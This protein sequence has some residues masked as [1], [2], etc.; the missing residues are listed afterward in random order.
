M[1]QQVAHRDRLAVGRD[2]P[3]GGELGHVLGQGRIEDQLAGVAQRQDRERRHVL[4]HRGDPERGVLAHPP[5]GL[6]VRQPQGHHMDEPSL[7]DDTGDK[8]R[9]LVLPGKSRRGSIDF[10]KHHG[11]LAG[12]GSSRR[13]LFVAGNPAPVPSPFVSQAGHEQR[14]PVVQRWH[15]R[16]P[17]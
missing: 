3:H 4:G 15:S 10:R 14:R 9:E 2:G 13:L 16:S 12:P 8:T 7:V 11:T 5:P 6:A 17:G 1:A